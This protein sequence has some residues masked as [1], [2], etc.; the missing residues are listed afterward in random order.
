[1]TWIFFIIIFNTLIIFKLLKLFQHIF[2]D[3]SLGPIHN[4]GEEMKTGT[5]T[6]LPLLIDREID[7]EF[8]PYNTIYYRKYYKFHTYFGL[9]KEFF[10]KFF[11]I[12]YKN[13]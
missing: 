1:M 7:V 2:S 6:V 9:N 11:F 4:T 5:I 10:K 3:T 13:T 8:K 12:T